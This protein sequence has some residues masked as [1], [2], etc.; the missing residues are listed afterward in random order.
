MDPV[1]L[2]TFIEGRFTFDCIAEQLA[3]MEFAPW[4]TLFIRKSIQIL[5][6]KKNAKSKIKFRK[7]FFIITKQFFRF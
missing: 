6:S 2:R 4:H 5:N 1:A 7:P 3:A